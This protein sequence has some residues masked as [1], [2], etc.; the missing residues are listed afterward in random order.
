M[1][2][3]ASRLVHEGIHAAEARAYP[4]SNADAA[5]ARRELAAGNA[6]YLSETAAAA[7]GILRVKIDQAA[8]W[9]RKG[10]NLK[11]ERD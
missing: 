7:R 8:S 5:A 3:L 6:L 10:L 2:G 11:S 4:S 1:A 9:E